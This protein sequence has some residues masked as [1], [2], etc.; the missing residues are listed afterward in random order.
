[1]GGPND[2][3]TTWISII[4]RNSP[5]FVSRQLT[6]T[7]IN[8]NHLPVLTFLY[9]QDGVSQ[10]FLA[11]HLFQDKAT[12]TRTLEVLDRQGLVKR[13][14]SPTDRRKKLVYITERARQVQADY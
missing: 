6:N 12:V 11:K 10:D 14:S 3:V 4:K 9:K 7:G 5:L 2:L 1:M 8:C 13:V